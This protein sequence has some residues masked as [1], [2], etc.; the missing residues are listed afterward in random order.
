MSL[1]NRCLDNRYVVLIGR[2]WIWTGDIMTR[3][4]VLKPANHFLSNQGEEY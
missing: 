2:K 3:Y 4:L 1:V